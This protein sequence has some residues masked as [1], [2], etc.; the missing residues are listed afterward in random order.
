MQAVN[1]IIRFS[2]TVIDTHAA[3]KVTLY[4]RSDFAGLLL[5]NVAIIVC[6]KMFDRE[7]RN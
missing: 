1:Y 7:S 6:L 3:F 4:L 5:W 2:T